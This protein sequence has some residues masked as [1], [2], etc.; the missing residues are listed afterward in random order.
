MSLAMNKM[1]AVPLIPESDLVEEDQDTKMHEKKSF[2][3]C[4]QWRKNNIK[5]FRYIFL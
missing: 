1:V 3:E 5:A 2:V 4:G